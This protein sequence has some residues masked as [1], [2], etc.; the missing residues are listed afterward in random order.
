MLP[1]RREARRLILGTFLVAVG[2][3]MTLPF[4]FVYLTKVRHIDATIVG[5]VVAWMGL[6]AIVLSGPAGA[7]IDRFGPR[8]VLLPL[9]VVESIGVASWAFDHT[10]WQAF[11]S[12]TLSAVGQAV[13]FGGQN[14]IMASVTS[15]AERQRVFGLGFAVLN[16]GIGMGGVVAGFIADVHHPGSF[17]VLYLTNAVA[18]LMPAL[19]LL[20]L[21]GVGRRTASVHADEGGARGGY[22]VVFANR[23]FRRFV[24]FAL[25]LMLSGYAQ[26]EVGFPAFASLVGGVSTRAIAWGLSANTV[27]IVLIQMVVI[28]RLEGRSRTRGLALVGVVIAVAWLV[29]GLTAWGRHLHAGVAAVGVAVA[30]SVFACGE[31]VMAPLMPAMTNVLATD[32]LRGR[33]NAVS[34]MIAGASGVLG[35]LTA[36][37][38]IGHGL[39]AVWIVLIVV[40][41]LVSALVALSL[42]GMLSPDQDGRAD[43]AVSAGSSGYSRPAPAE[44]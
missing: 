31:T 5:V 42:H 6:L 19:I 14:T 23:A 29:L 26:F 33:Y 12:A 9:Y 37:P 41:A 4:L 7:L 3:G 36:A 38:L 15:P 22:R 1:E 32:E 13:L 18:S 2:I 34:G 20:S 40:G 27:T 11:V 10:A 39:G 8:R 44:R 30:A 25:L 35:P 21:P 28:K 24:I 43:A 17:R 16:L